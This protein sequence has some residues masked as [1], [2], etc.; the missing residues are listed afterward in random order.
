M[1]RRGYYWLLYTV[2]LFGLFHIVIHRDTTGSR[3]PFPSTISLNIVKPEIKFPSKEYFHSFYFNWKFETDTLATYEFLNETP[4]LYDFVLGSNLIN[5]IRSIK[6]LQDLTE[7]LESYEFDPRITLA[8]Y[9]REILLDVRRNKK[10]PFSWYDWKDLG[11]QLNKFINLKSKDRPKCDFVINHMFPK[12]QLV[13]LEG[14]TRSHIFEFGRDAY[15][16]S[17][18]SNKAVDTKRYCINKQQGMLCPG[19]EVKEVYEDSRP[20]SLALQVAS[21]LLNYGVRPLSI[22]I[23]LADMGVLQVEIEQGKKHSPFGMNELF[24]KY[25]AGMEPSKNLTFNH[26]YLFDLLRRFF[27]KQKTASNLEFLREIPKESFDFDLDSAIQELELSEKRQR[28]SIHDS[29]YLKSLKYSKTKGATKYTHFRS[30][31]TFQ[32]DYK[33]QSKH[34]DIRFFSGLIPS[35][36]DKLT[37]LN[38]LIR[39]WFQFMNSQHFTSWL[40]RGSLYSYLNN[41]RQFPWDDGFKVH[42]PLN[43]LTKLARK[44]NQ[45]LIV[46]NPREGNGRFFLD[47]SPVMIAAGFQGNGYIDARFIDVDTGLYVGISSV[48][49]TSYCIKN[50]RIINNLL[51][52]IE[53]TFGVTGNIVDVFSEIKKYEGTDKMLQ[54]NRENNLLSYKN[55]EL[56]RLD[57]ISP[58]RLSVYH[59]VATYVV[60][61]PLKVLRDRYVVSRYFYGGRM[62]Y[63]RYRYFPEPAMWLDFKD[64]SNLIGSVD[65]IGGLTFKAVEE[66]AYKMA[67]GSGNLHQTLIEWINSYELSK[68]RMLELSVQVDENLSIEQKYNMLEALTTDMMP[69]KSPFKDPFL[70]RYQRRMWQKLAKSMF[71][72]GFRPSDLLDQSVIDFDTA[73][74]HHLRDV[75]N[76]TLNETATKFLEKIYNNELIYNFSKVQPVFWIKKHHNEDDNY[77]RRQ[78]FVR[79]FGLDNNNSNDD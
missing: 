70:D 62:K 19:F 71:S 67:S 75:I 76:T 58:L 54:F 48:Q 24:Q 25:I 43:E 2:L 37:A 20:E 56:F 53:Q 8:V 4:T 44:F 52:N 36:W 34:M 49:F 35:N 27:G 64:I 29:N 63:F 33:G 16:S 46:Q 50:E 42:M 1:R 72:I 45:S 7:G 18:E 66:L 55:Q 79:D 6:T 17:V 11:S 12:D 21:Y 38:S 22:S 5:R 57:D 39:S 23:I 9:F 3:I 77:R 61:H 59:G 69:S 31:I 15:Y 60:N 73:R 51:E 74:F 30:P 40:I 26:L 10:L 32:H 28:L 47:I 14:L 78:P 13:R 41:A 65:L 68:Y